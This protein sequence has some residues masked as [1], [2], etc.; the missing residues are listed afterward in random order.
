IGTNKLPH[1]IEQIRNTILNAGG[2]I[3]FN[4]KVVDILTRFDSVTGVS[5]EGGEM[6]SATS[7]IVATGHS[8]RAIFDL[9]ARTGWMMEAK[10]FALGV[11]IEHPQLLIDQSQYHCDIRS[12]FLPPAYYSLVEQVDE[13][14]VFSFC[15]CP[16]GIIAPCATA[17]GE[18][19]VNGWSPSKRN[20]PFANSGTVVQVQLS[21]VPGA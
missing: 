9:F 1:I 18:I 6:I 3:H 4:T 12:E 21:D 2:E 5:L 19:V 7:V 17:E 13:R 16:G 8:A 20:N 10:L 15:M 14:G 11:R